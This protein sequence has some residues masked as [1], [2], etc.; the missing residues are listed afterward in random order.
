ML[1][2]ESFTL[3]V[4]VKLLKWPEETYLI[5]KSSRAEDFITCS[6]L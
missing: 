6:C 3:L 5:L 1:R 2:T 4:S